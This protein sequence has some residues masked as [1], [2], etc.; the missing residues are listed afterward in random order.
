MKSEENWLGLTGVDL[1]PPVLT[2]NKG[3]GRQCQKIVP[4]CRLSHLIGKH[5]E[6]CLHYEINDLVSGRALELLAKPVNRQV[7]R[8]HGIKQEILQILQGLGIGEKGCF[9]H[10]PTI[11]DPG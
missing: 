7:S 3:S 5:L 10:A 9:V 8:C 4:P 1:S 6:M 2:H 11:A